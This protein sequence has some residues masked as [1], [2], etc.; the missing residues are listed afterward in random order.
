MAQLA[1]SRWPIALLAAA[2][3]AA[4]V[5]AEA[6][7]ASFVK[8]ETI[9]APDGSWDIAAWDTTHG[10]LL[11]AHGRD[12]LVVDPAHGNA[13]HEFGTLEG[14]HG[15]LALPGG[16][17]A[18]VA[19]GK[20]NTVRLIDET[21]GAEAARIAV[22]EDPDAAIL[23]QDGKN[24]F[25]MDA[26]GALSVLNLAQRKETQRIVLK[27]GLEFPVQY[28]PDKVA[29]NNED[30]NEIE[31]ADLATGKMAGAIA[32]TGCTGPTGMAYDAVTGLSLSTCANGKAALVD[33]A[34]R[35]LVA[36]VSIGLGPDTAIWDGSHRRFLVP[37]GKSGTLSII[38]MEGRKPVVE[39]EVMTE[40][41][42]RTAAY[43]PSTGR[44]YLP[45]ARFEAPVPPAKR[46]AMIPGTF[47]ILVM[48]PVRG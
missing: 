33:L 17:L 32:L 37:C 12:L 45:S 27:P 13:V 26:G 6:P 43:D 20:D 16:N 35:K 3:L 34:S 25:V 7:A 19:S 44:L 28:A 21:N 8:A 2:S 42:A 4:P 46:G 23:S 22:G 11:V 29:V 38:H 36:L 40:V 31:L 24:A 10:K 1:H 15:V 30:L 47:H 41:S 14:A 9:A 39:P 18:L 5:Q 48:G